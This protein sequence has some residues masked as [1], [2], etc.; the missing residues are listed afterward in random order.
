MADLIAK[1]TAA[2]A[3]LF[4]TPEYNFSIPGGLK[5]AIDWFSRDPNKGFVGK[6]VGIMGAS[7][8]PLGTARV[9]Y[10][11]RQACV[12][13]DMHPV[14]KPEVFIGMAHTKFDAEGQSDRRTDQDLYQPIARR[15]ARLGAQDRGLTMSAHLGQLI[16]YGDS[17]SGN[18]QKVRYVSDR[19]G[20]PYKWIETSVLKAETRA[21]SF[22][23]LNPA[24]QVPGGRFPRRT[25]PCPVE[26]DHPL[27][28][29]RFGFDSRRP[30]RSCGHGSM[31]VLGAIQP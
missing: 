17:I 14:N 13:L 12:F 15:A 19:L 5:N 22:L 10:H 30:F 2:N 9:Q 27:S 31:V 25:Q 6:A 4:A 18:C 16:V 1:V 3:I 8:G 20:I 28:G 7:G 21:P 11:L 29:R 23:H 26:R 24:G